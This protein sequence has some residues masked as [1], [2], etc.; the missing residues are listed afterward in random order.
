MAQ[1]GFEGRVGRCAVRHAALLGALAEDAYDPPGPVDVGEVEPAQFGD[2]DPGGVQQFEY[3]T[4]PHGDRPAGFGRRHQGGRL[5]GAQHRRQVPARPRAGQALPD[6]GRE[7]PLPVRPRAER[8]GRGAPSGERGA[9]GSGGT[10]PGQPAAQNREVQVG[11][12]GG[13]H[14][15]RVVEQRHDVGDVRPDG[16]PG[17][18]A[19]ARQVRGERVRGVAHRRRQLLVQRRRTRVARTSHGL[20]VARRPA[21]RQAAAPGRP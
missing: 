17:P 11:R 10:Q 8:A 9:R 6:V 14:P 1:P 16:M 7:Q 4:V 5:L 18:V 15:D 13:A 3:H 2:P 19:L 12:R 20:T 21:A